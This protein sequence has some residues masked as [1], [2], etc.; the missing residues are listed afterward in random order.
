LP[1]FYEKHPSAISFPDR[2]TN[3]NYVELDRIVEFLQLLEDATLFTESHKGTMEKW[4][5]NLEF[6]I[7]CFENGKERY[8]DNAFLSALISSGWEKLNNTLLR[9]N[10]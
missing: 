3:D 7:E 9:M 5:P 6:V 10:L 8:K 2:I 4:L 1:K